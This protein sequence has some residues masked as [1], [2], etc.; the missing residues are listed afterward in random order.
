[1]I[2]PKVLILTS[3]FGNGHIQVAKTLEQELQ[4]MGASVVVKDLFH[5]TNPKV[6]EWT[7]RL[8]LKSY[9][10]SGRQ[11]YR[12][13]YYSSKLLSKRKSFKSFKYGITKLKQIIEEEK[14][15]LIINTFP[16]FAAPIL[17]R[18]S[19][20][21]TYNVI[22]DYCLHHSW[23]HSNIK[24]YY[25]ATKQ[26][27][28]ELEHANVPGQ[29]VAVSGIP[30]NRQF[31]ENYNIQHL[32]LKYRLSP[33]KQTVLIVAGAFGVSQEISE[34][35]NLLKDEPHIQLIV[36]CGKNEELYQ[37]L[38]YNFH[39]FDHIKVYGY[40]NVMA[41]L[42]SLSSCVITKA[43]GII[44][45]EAMAMQTP[46]V[47]LRATPGQERENA[48]YFQK[49]GSA[50]MCDTID[51]LVHETKGLI[52]NKQKQSEMKS[53]INKMHIPN[54]SMKICNDIMH[55]YYFH[56]LKYRKRDEVL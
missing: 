46:I 35:C 10:T 11:L 52:R 40:V 28:E 9:T 7:K 1:M 19:Q 20:I 18:G 2:L 8:Y 48:T 36:V 6:N 41:E 21:A 37:S 24:K 4:H 32:V 29:K 45:T 15:D 42:L 43:G 14:P 49:Q 31:D 22:T 53:A 23:I 16:S 5:E 47:L 56:F 50:I 55:D 13:F 44:L 54:S 17:S 39:S 34:I 26:L 51:K 33:T 38:V 27:K 12:L 30:V 25:V 3:K